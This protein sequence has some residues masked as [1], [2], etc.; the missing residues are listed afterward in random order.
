MVDQRRMCFIYIFGEDM[1]WLGDRDSAIAEVFDR[2]KSLK[3]NH[4]S[5]H[6]PTFQL[7]YY[8][9]Y[10]TSFKNYCLIVCFKLRCIQRQNY[11]FA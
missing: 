6:K 10:A 4:I 1:K 2:I 9:I 8:L 11:L 5:I 7:I 3:P